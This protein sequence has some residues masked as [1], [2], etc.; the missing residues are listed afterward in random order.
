MFLDSRNAVAV[1]GDAKSDDIRRHIPP[2]LVNS[3]GI[4]NR[5][6][7]SKYVVGKLGEITMINPCKPGDSK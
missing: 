4:T 1:S 2:K 3:K 5:L 7:H 6:P